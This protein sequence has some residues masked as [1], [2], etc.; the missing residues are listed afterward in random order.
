VTAS[1][2]KLLQLADGRRLAYAEFGAPQGIPV[3]YFHGS[4]S[5]RLEP[6]LV[7]D[8]AWAAHGLRVVAFDRPGIGGSSAAA[9][10]GFVPGARDG[11]ALADALGWPRFALLGNSGG[12]PYV[13][14]ATTLFP[15]RVSQAVI[16]SGGWRMDWPEARAGL[17]FVNRLV[18]TLAHRAPWLL[19]GLLAGMGRVGTGDPSRELAQL[20]ARV[21]PP[22]A[23][24]F[25]APGRLA[26]FAASM[27]EALRQ[28]THAAA[29]ELGLYVRP[30]DFEPAAV[31][32]RIA[33]FHGALDGNAPIALARRAVASL[34]GASLVEFAQEAHLSALCEQVDVYAPRLRAPSGA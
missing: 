8:E 15:E 29:R 23:A 17:P 14:A 21:P 18:M 22:D 25:A 13:A 1:R 9:A 16:V 4:P 19:R 20:S 10:I 2:E 11:L 7:G 27:H 31:R 6:L 33:W 28:G 24:A 5:S 3:L 30:F 26:A 34:P 32:V 12:A